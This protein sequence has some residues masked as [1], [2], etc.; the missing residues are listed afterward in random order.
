M[1]GINSGNSE[2]GQILL[3]VVLAS[4]IS[5]TVGLAAVSRSITN[6][7]ISTEEAN[8]QKALAAAEAGVEE[9]INKARLA[10]GG[11]VTRSE[12][13]L[14]N[15]SNFLA[16]ARPISGQYFEVNAGESV[17]Q[18]DGADIWIANY[19]NLASPRNTNLTV[20]WIAEGGDCNDHAAI[21]V[22]VIEGGSTT[23]P[24]MNR[25]AYDACG[26]RRGNNN[27]DSGVAATPPSQI[28][29]F[30]NYN[31]RTAVIPISGGF[32]AR[33]IP[34]YA[35]ARIAVQSTT[36]LPPQGYEI[37]STGESGSTVR[38]VTVFQGFPKV[39]IEFFP[40]NL[41]VP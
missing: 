16:T 11:S 10:A 15:N 33:V 18:D 12:Q 22:A 7:R 37:E 28:S 25:Y 19:N 21:E 29:S 35:D 39:P 8:S 9:Q 6:T 4:V 5:L 1:P 30:G 27:F 31:R 32:I 24:T 41:F 20:W 38:K 2:K 40:Y 17:P 13:N 14:N 23:N 34:L 36:S 26:G 3:I